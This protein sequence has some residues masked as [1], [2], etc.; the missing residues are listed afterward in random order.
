MQVGRIAKQTLCL[1]GQMPVSLSDDNNNNEAPD[2]LPLSKRDRE[3][4]NLEVPV[5]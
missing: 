1:H 3:R 4:E 2:S 5:V